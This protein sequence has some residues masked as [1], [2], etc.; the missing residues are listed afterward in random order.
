MGAVAG[1]PRVGR[2]LATL[3][4]LL[5]CACTRQTLPTRQVLYTPRHLGRAASGVTG[6]VQNVDHGLWRAPDGVFALPVAPFPRG[7]TEIVDAY[8]SGGVTSMVSML[9]ASESVV[10]VVR[11]RI[12]A[13]LPEQDVLAR[14]E[15]RLRSMAE[16]LSMLTLEWVTQ[17]GLRQL[18][19]TNTEPSYDGRDDLMDESMSEGVAFG[20]RGTCRMDRRFVHSGYYFQVIAIAHDVGETACEVASELVSWAVESIQIAPPVPTA[21]E[22]ASERSS[23]PCPTCLA[24]RTHHSSGRRASLDSS[25][26]STASA[27]RPSPRSCVSRLVPMKRYSHVIRR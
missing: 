10:Q 20:R 22:G 8:G 9:D 7:P 1:A 11:T 15:P 26:R 16:G 25:P 18:Q 17:R 4:V 13:D 24:P 2:A 3:G 14:V 6:D 5:A 27:S 23:R 12:R 19:T 21:K